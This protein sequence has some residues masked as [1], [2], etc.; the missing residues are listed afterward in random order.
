MRDA[1][2][3]DTVNYH[4]TFDADPARCRAWCFGGDSVVFYD[5]EDEHA[6][7]ACQD[8]PLTVDYR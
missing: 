6:W 2:M 5:P 8:A 1:T 3:A 4:H 7:L